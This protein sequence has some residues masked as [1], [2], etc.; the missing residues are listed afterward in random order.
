MT[1]TELSA[2]EAAICQQYDFPIL[3]KPFLPRDI[4]ET[5]RSRIPGVSVARQI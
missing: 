5:V 2:E 3:R 1:G 4:V